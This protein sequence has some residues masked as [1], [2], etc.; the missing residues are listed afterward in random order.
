[1]NASI[2][3]PKRMQKGDITSVLGLNWHKINDHLLI[4]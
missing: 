1:M 4:H 3:R 2:T